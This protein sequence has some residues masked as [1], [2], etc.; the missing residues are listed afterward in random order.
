MKKFLT[1]ISVLVVLG[2]SVCSCN[3]NKKPT[4]KNTS[5]GTV[6][7]NSVSEE[8]STEDSISEIET[9]PTTPTNAP[10]DAKLS[11]DVIKPLINYFKSYQDNDAELLLESTTPKFCLN[12]AKETDIYDD[13]VLSAK[14]SIETSVVL[15]KHTYGDNVTREFIEEVQNTTFTP[16]QIEWANMMLKYDYYGID[17][18]FEVAEGYEIVF[19]YTLKGDKDEKTDEQAACLINI[20]DEGWILLEQNAESLIDYKDVPPPEEIAKTTESETSAE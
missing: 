2:C 5:T 16:E 3:N 11:E 7:E 12:W 4:S 15:W 6:T 17:S 14:D 13:A 1:A 10:N 8:S 18:D 9:T 20:K 19:R